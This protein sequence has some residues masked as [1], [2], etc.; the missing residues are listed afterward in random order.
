MAGAVALT[1]SDAHAQTDRTDDGDGAI[2]SGPDAAT[3]LAPISIEARAASE[4]GQTGYPMPAYAGGQVATGGGLGI[5]GNKGFMETPFNQTSYT[6]EYLENTQAQTLTQVLEASPSIRRS[7]GRYSSE[8]NFSIRGFSASGVNTTYDGFYG[9]G[10]Y[11][12][13]SLQEIARVEVLKGPSALLYGAPPDGGVGGTINL[14]PKRATDAPITAFHFSY[15]EE[16]LFEG[17]LDVGRRFGRNNAF[18]IRV[19]AVH[20]DGDTPFDNNAEK[21]SLGSVA[22][23]YLGEDLRLFANFNYEDQQQD[24]AGFGSFVAADVPIPAPPDGS[25]NFAAPFTKTATERNYNILRAEYDIHENWMAEIGYAWQESNEL[26]YVNFASQ[27]LNADG[28]YAEP[29]F[30]RFREGDYDYHS[31]KARLAGRFETGPVTH[32]VAISAYSL[33]RDTNSWTRN[34]FGEGVGGG[35]FNIYDPDT[36]QYT[37]PDF[38]TIEPSLAQFELVQQGVAVSDTLGVLDDRLQVTIGVREQRLENKNVGTGVT[39]YDESRLTPAFAVMFRAHERVALYGNYIEGL[40][41]AP[42]P[43]SDALNADDVFD[44][45]QTEQIEFGAKMNLGRFAA[46]VSLFEITQPNSRTNPETNIFRLDGEQRN[47]GIELETFGELIPGLR[48]LGGLAFIDP[49]LTRTQNGAND[50]NNASGTP[51]LRANLYAEWDACFLRTL[52]FTGQLIHTDEQFVDSANTRAIPSWNRIDL[53]ARYVTA[54]H[55]TDV[56]LR[57]RV[58]NVLDA[59]Y[60]ENS[61]LALGEPRN[62]SLS[63]SLSF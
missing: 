27:I 61:G 42:S 50:G 43:P 49:E 52:T 2:A 59:K 45:V 47:R 14:V 28:D 38:S 44:P 20:G 56:T 1:L 40:T 5:L 41:E 48:L 51:E 58:T 19:N 6:A 13:N 24:A 12:R 25:N 36:S 39:N 37:E 9:L 32:T 22:L 30:Y 29:T 18:G 63:M 26:Q 33:T 21:L 16:S 7:G 62:I 53:G 60:W 35:V 31:M 17:H 8:E 23:D 11:R 55:D 57:L 15:A 10:T 34:A 4:L 3:E 46:T 54:V